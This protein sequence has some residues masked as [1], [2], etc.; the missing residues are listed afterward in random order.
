MN[1]ELANKVQ[2]DKISEDK[3]SE[4]T[5]PDYTN[6]LKNAISNSDAIVYGSEEINEEL[7]SLIEKEN[8]LALHYNSE[9]Y[10]EAYLDFYREIISTN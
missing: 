9:D 3:I 1:N 8:K 5:E 6:I 2:F 4:L 10:S 7:S